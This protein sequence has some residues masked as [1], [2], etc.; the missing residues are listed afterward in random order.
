MVD[1]SAQRRKKITQGI[2]CCLDKNGRN[3]KICP[4]H[5]FG[6]FRCEELKE[7][8]LRMIRREEIEA[9]D[10]TGFQEGF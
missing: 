4:Y 6:Y 10:W 9:S 1:C 2:E 8:I 7:D 5:S 3:C